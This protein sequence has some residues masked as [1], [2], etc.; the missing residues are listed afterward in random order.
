MFISLEEKNMRSMTEY[1]SGKMR[2]RH[3]KMIRVEKMKLY[4]Q[5]GQIYELEKM[6][7]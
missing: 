6:K 5:Y 3:D 4:A 1:D 7:Y 2:E